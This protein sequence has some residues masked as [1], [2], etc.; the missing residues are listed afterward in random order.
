MAIYD[1]D[2]REV[3]DTT[4]GQV[5]TQQ[6]P[7]MAGFVITDE[8]EGHE[9]VVCEYP[10]GGRDVSWL[11]DREPVGEWRFF[12]ESGAE[13]QNPPKPSIEPWWSTDDG[14][15]YACYAE[16]DL[17]TPYSEEEL[18]EIKRLE[19]E[20]ERE[21]E[22]EQEQAELVAALPDA[23]LELGDLAADNSTNV[24]ALTDAIMEL[25]QIVSDLTEGTE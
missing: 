2:W 16:W 9:S 19:A 18:A 10:N 6:Q 1:K 25:A 11:W 23:V 4:L 24:E 7:L 8:G 22:L 15:M 20:R 17:Y 12:D 3:K 21:E 5:L 14:G 13:W